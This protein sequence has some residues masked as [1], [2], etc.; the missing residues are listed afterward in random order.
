[1]KYKLTKTEFEAL[2]E[3]AKKEYILSGESAVLKIEGEGAP[4]AEALTRAEDKLRIEK[5]HRR[6]AETARDTAETRSEKLKKDLEGASGKEEIARIKAEHQTELETIRTDRATEQKAAKESS[7][8]AMIKEAAEKFTNEHFITPGL[9]VGPFSS[10]LSV[11]EIDGQSV[12]RVKDA[13][14]KASAMSLN[15]LQK[16][17]LDN[18]EYF[19]IIKANAGRGGGAT[20]GGGDG[21]SQKKLAEMTAKEEAD[22]ER[23]N[24]DGY[25]A[26][27]AEEA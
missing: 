17:F 11:E 20:P 5:E 16:E 23:T 7:N 12:I 8:A 21:V 15:E 6:N 18:K 24:P 1:M 9:M 3:E 4:T 27:I 14:G 2:G 25:K 26:A 19:P 10:R 22:F 13:E